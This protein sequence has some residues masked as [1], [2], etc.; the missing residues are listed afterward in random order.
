MIKYINKTV[1][2]TECWWCQV[3][4]EPGRFTFSVGIN[5]Q[6]GG[7]LFHIHIGFWEIDLLFEKK[8]D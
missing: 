2:E 8:E 5:W 3:Y 6:F 4:Q 7:P 1:F